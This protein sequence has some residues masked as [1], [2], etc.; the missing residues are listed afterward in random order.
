MPL[1]HY[2]NGPLSATGVVESVQLDE[3]EIDQPKSQS[4]ELTVKVENIQLNNEKIDTSH[5]ALLKVL[6]QGSFGKVFLVR[7]LKGSDKDTFYAM[8]V[9]KKASLKIRDRERTKLERN[10]LA[11]IKHPFIVELFY[12]MQTE[13]KL[14]L[15]LE[16]V[17]GGDLFTRLSR[18]YCLLKKMCNFILPSSL[19]PFPI[20]T[21][22]ELFIAI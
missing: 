15:V 21:H 12:A 22:S 4:N 18:E 10:I 13:G 8:K 14:Y 3:M 11:D 5:F 17:Q 16:F 20:F 2:A 6:G 9:L 1:N 19:V 7:K